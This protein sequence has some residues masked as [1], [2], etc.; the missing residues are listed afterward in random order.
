[1][2]EEPR[3]YMGWAAT[4]GACAR[5]LNVAGLHAEALRCSERVCEHMHD[6]DRPF[7]AMFLAAE[8]ELAVARA[9]TGDALGAHA[10]L[11]EL[12]KFHVGSDNPLTRGRIHEACA[13]VALLLDDRAAFKHHLAETRAWFR[14]T[15]SPVLIARAESLG[16]SGRLS[17]KPP[18]SAPLGASARP[19]ADAGTSTDTFVT[20]PQRQRRPTP[21]TS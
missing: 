8:L 7:V 16:A 6:E 14:A 5:A 19:P 10:Q 1:L 17:S 9:A 2:A 21:P 20:A 3:G 15:G 11:H 4:L 13:R 18:R 12:L